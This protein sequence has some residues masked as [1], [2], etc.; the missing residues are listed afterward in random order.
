MKA[1]LINSAVKVENAD[2][3][4]DYTLYS[5]KNRDW[6]Q[7]NAYTDSRIPLDLE[8]GSGQ[9]NAWR[10]LQQFQS[11]SH[12][13]NQPIPDVAWDYDTIAP[14]QTITYN[15]A[16]HLKANSF[17]TVTLVWDRQIKL[18]DDNQNQQY[19]LGE[20]FQAEPLTNLDL[21]LVKTASKNPD[22]SAKI[23]CAS[24]SQVDNIEHFF[25][26]IP[27]T[28]SYQIQVKAPANST[29]TNQAY[30]L[31]WWTVASEE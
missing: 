18:L 2:L 6:L 4:M 24:Q 19:D 23:V 22:Q 29:N 21:F 25:C 9:L 30:A 15:L 27:Q 5:K 20:I 31:S 3:G 11:G 16:K 1:I 12:S 10:A 14:Q 8:M 17:A 13:P 28:G 26:P 7:S